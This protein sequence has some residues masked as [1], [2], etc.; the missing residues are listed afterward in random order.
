MDT[1]AP[2][3]AAR[4]AE[5]SSVLRAL[6]RG[7]FA[8][9]GVV[10]LL[11]GAIVIVISF[12]GRGESDQAGAFMAIASAPLG[13]VA[14]WVLA[15]A[16]CAL[17]IWHAL[18]GLLAR[19]T[20]DDAKGF[21]K[22]WGRR[23]SEWGQ[24]CIFIALGVVAIAVAL[25]ARVDS[26]ESAE[27]A[28]HGI[29]LLPGG[30]VMLGLLGLGIGIGGVSFVVMG[31]LRSF[32]KQLSIPSGPL[33]GVVTALGVIGFI[34]KGVAL[35]IVGFLL[36]VAAATVDASTAGGLDGAV[37]ALLNVALGPLLVCL[38]GIG[39]VAYGVFCIFRARYARL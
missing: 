21:A 30:P 8:A 19:N 23:I 37:Q 11:I 34:A 36:V 18:E 4:K 35:V 32:Q 24:A 28:S 17:G 39:F 7:G 15:V 1:A 5:S 31:V 25:G 3:R 38:V 20:R 22:K 26:E 2:K 33:G 16:L 6:A 14:L 9:N 10:H 12:G 27:N 29:L 13:F